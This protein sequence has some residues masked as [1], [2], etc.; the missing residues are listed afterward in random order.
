[1]KNPSPQTDAQ[2]HW[3]SDRQDL[4]GFV[5]TLSFSGLLRYRNWKLN[6]M[7]VIK[8]CSDQSYWCPEHLLQPSCS[9]AAGSSRSRKSQALPSLKMPM[10]KYFRWG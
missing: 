10:L 6:H 9:S 7:W 4:P 1:M 5:E 8:L 2:Q 3:L